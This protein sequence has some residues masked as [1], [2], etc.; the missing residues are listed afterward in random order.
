MHVDNDYVYI[1]IYNFRMRVIAVVAQKGGVGKTTLATC[2]AVEGERRGYLTSILDLDP[3]ATASF[4]HDTRAEET[5]V[6]VSLQASRIRPVLKSAEERGCD[7]AILD[8]AAIARDVIYAAS[9]S[10]DYVLVP[11]KSSVFD[12]TSLL[13]TVEIIRQTDRPLSVV[14]NFVAPSGVEIQDALELLS[15]AKIR[16]SPARIGNRKAIFRAQGLGK[17]VQETDP[18]SKATVEFQALFDDIVAEM[19]EETP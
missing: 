7:F 16:V 13:E 17:T 5:P 6:V 1:V 12:M 3:Q 11:T 14:L 9:A 19:K 18:R 10:A 8:A 4:W 2:L 15:R